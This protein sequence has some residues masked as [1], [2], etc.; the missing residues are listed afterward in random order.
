MES[1]SF[2]PASA[3]LTCLECQ[4]PI[5]VVIIDDAFYTKHW[6][7]PEIA[8]FIRSGYTVIS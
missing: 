1:E 3:T 5:D 4:Q 7:D 8:E 6:C 2:S